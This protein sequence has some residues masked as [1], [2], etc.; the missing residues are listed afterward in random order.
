MREFQRG[1]PT[2]LDAGRNTFQN[3]A[4]RRADC[5]GRK[6]GVVVFFKV[7]RHHKTE[8]ALFV[9]RIPFHQNE[10][11]FDF[12]KDVFVQ[13]L[14]HIFVDFLNA[15]FAVVRKINFGENQIER[16]GCIADICGEFLPVFGLRRELIAGND[17]PFFK[18]DAVFRQQ[19]IFDFYRFH[20][21]K[22]LFLFFLS[23]TSAFASMASGD[24]P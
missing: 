12:L 9:R 3:G 5:H 16:A 2:N 20:L 24:M 22:N 21:L 13:V 10:T 18:I 17:R 7:D 6:R 14:I 1:V 19:Y 11:V 4:F 15:V 8:P 23:A